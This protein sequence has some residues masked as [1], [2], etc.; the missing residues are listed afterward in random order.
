[1]EVSIIAFLVAI[2]GFMMTVDHRVAQHPSLYFIGTAIWMGAG[3]FLMITSP[4]DGE[5]APL[6]HLR[7]YRAMGACILFA[8]VAMLC[9]R[10][11]RSYGFID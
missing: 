2:F 9:H 11:F 7:T 4:E 3:L 1:M 10:I 6:A 5:E 8:A